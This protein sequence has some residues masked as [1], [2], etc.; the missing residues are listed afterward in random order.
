MN[1]KKCGP[2]E[3]LESLGNTLVYLLEGWLPW[4]YEGEEGAIELKFLDERSH[5]G[6]QFRVIRMYFDSLEKIKWGE[7]PDYEYLK[8]L[9]K[10]EIQKL[11]GNE[12][13]AF[14]WEEPENHSDGVVLPSMSQLNSTSPEHTVDDSK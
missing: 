14:D 6:G 9:F 12:D 1:Q 3:D 11:N 13:D 2:R 5:V 4:E 7:M 10:E 8:L